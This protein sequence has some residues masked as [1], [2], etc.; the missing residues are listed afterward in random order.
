MDIALQEEKERLHLRIQEIKAIADKEIA[1]VHIPALKEKFAG[2][3]FKYQNSYGPSTEKWWMYIY[4]QSVA[5]VY[6]LADGNPIAT[7]SGWSFQTD[8]HGN[9]EIEVN[10]SCYSTDLT[11]NEITQKEFREHY[12]NMQ[13]QLSQLPG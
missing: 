7:L 4:V 1:E 2:K 11:I 5:D 12:D 9:V 6:M 8:C 10:K 13:K 3:Y